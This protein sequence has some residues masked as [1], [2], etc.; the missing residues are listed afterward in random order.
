M[1]VTAAT[2]LILLDIEGTTSSIRF[3]TE[4]MFPFVR[5]HLCEFLKAE[6]NQAGLRSALGA[7]ARDLGKGSLETWLPQ[8]MQDEARRQLVEKSVMQLM[9]RDAKTTGLKELQGMI[10]RNGFE[11]GELV[12][13]VY[14]DVPPALQSWKQRGLDLRIYSSGSIGAQKL[15]FGHS[16]AGNLLPLFSNHYDTKTGGKKDP[17]SYQR[18][19]VDAGLLPA[20]ILFV[21][22]VSDELSA[23]SE[24]GFQVALSIRPDNPPQPDSTSFV[25]IRKFS[26]IRFPD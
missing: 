1:L 7:L 11:S 8:E 15:F 12:A 20:E 10:W 21:S 22:D 24:C 2:R 17:D 5:S 16:I 23:A 9:D 6:W 13:H 19:A 14:A 25:E 3:V 4:V 26:D 18:I